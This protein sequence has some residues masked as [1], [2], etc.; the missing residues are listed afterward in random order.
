LVAGLMVTWFLYNRLQKHVT[1]NRHRRV[2]PF[3]PFHEGQGHCLLSSSFFRQS[4]S[5]VELASRIGSRAS[6]CNYETVKEFRGVSVNPQAVFW[7]RALLTAE[8]CANVIEA[9]ED[10]GFEERKFEGKGKDSSSCVVW[11][12]ELAEAIFARLSRRTE[13][14]LLPLRSYYDAS[15]GIRLDQLDFHNQDV[16]YW[17]RL[18]GCNP[19]C[20]VERYRPGQHLKIHRDGAV[21]VRGPGGGSRIVDGNAR[22]VFSGNCSGQVYTVH[23]VLVYLNADFSRG[24]TDF[25]CGLEKDGQYHFEGTKGAIG[26]ALIF[27][28]ELLHRGGHVESGIK[29]ILRLDLAFEMEQK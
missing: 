14:S 12:P 8:E 11:C 19:S 2:V 1:V 24:T 9:A 21:L 7:A 28:H 10:T 15:P 27:R 3:Q 22:D 23:A 25:V 20:R 6:A 4:P 17:G 26:D 16:T 13:G 29:Y 18:V 5:F